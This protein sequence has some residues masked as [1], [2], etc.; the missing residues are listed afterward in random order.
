LRTSSDT[1]RE[2]WT[3]FHSQTSGGVTWVRMVVVCGKFSKNNDRLSQKMTQIC[4][5][6]AVSCVLL[7]RK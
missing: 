7:G 6:N 1:Y 3:I 2:D 4:V 5:F